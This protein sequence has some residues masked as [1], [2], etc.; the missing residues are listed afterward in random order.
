MHATIEFEY[1]MFCHSFGICNLKLWFILLS[2]YL[3]LFYTGRNHIQV[4]FDHETG[5]SKC[6][7]FISFKEH[8]QAEAAVEAMDGKE[9]DGKVWI[10]NCI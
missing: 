9:I 5:K 6:F 1:D 10:Y 2:L 3:E 4:A 8:D 7:C